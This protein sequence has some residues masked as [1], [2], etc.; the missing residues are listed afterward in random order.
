MIIYKQLFYR[1]YERTIKMNSIIPVDLNEDILLETDISPTADELLALVCEQPF[2]IDV[3]LERTL[4]PI[5]RYAEDNFGCNID[6]NTL[7]T[8]EGHTSVEV[9]VQQFARDEDVSLALSILKDDGLV[10]L[11]KNTVRTLAALLPLPYSVCNRCRTRHK[12]MKCP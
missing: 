9:K 11:M 8:V 12:C 1:L 10:S 2:L 3:T 4:P 6:I 5:K 7:C